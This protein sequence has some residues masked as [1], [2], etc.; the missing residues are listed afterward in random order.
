MSNGDSHTILAGRRC[1]KSSCLNAI[2]YELKQPTTI[3]EGHWQPLVIPYDLTRKPLSSTE[4]FW[5]QILHETIS[6][7]SITALPRPDDAWSEPTLLDAGWFEE[8]KEKKALSTDEFQKTIT[9][10]VQKLQVAS[11][12]PIRLV[13]LLD[14]TDSVLARPWHN[15]F[16]E[17]SRA[18]LVDANFAK[19]IRIVAAGSER[20]SEIVS[21]HGSPWWNIFKAQYLEALDEQAITELASRIPDLLSETKEVVWQYCGG[22]PFIAQYILYHLWGRDIAQADNKTIESIASRFLH[23]RQN[24]LEGWARAVGA[25][26]LQAYGIIASNPD[27]IAEDDILHATSYPNAE[28]TR[29]LKALGYHGIVTCDESWSYYRRAGTMFKEWYNSFGQDFTFRLEQERERPPQP[30]PTPSSISDSDEDQSERT[31]PITELPLIVHALVILLVMVVVAIIA[32]LLPNDRF[33]PFF[34]ITTL[35]LLVLL[36]L[37]NKLTGGQLLEWL[38][39]VTDKLLTK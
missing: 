36:V 37:A 30:S 12:P 5:A 29:A 14:E 39:V 10:I 9:Y 21:N 18:L 23:E 3:D 25:V 11:K 38:S 4:E 27:W 28:V 13:L 31:S 17:G 33:I 15:D 22:H 8:L 20:V 35:G 2:A 26:G 24:D 7:V 19:Y 6:R 1:G 16:L 34:F 32:S